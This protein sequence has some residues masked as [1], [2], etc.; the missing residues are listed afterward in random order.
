MGRFHYGGWEVELI[1]LP[2]VYSLTAFSLDQRIALQYILNERP[3]V[4]VDI[5]DAG[6]L[7][8]NLYLTLLLLE[9]EVR[10][11]VVLNKMDRAKAKGL[12]VNAEK[13]SQLLGVPVVPTIAPREVGLEELKPKIVEVAQAE[14]WQPPRLYY[15]PEL[16]QEIT[17]LEEGLPQAELASGYPRRWL[18]IKHLEGDGEAISRLAKASA[19]D[20]GGSS[21]DG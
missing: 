18:A 14:D 10:L 17:K 19:S 8:R 2:G 7:G 5:V 20:A 11:L 1:D 9:L 12:Q 16:E 4:V 6:N 15:G 21:G 13:L 3:E